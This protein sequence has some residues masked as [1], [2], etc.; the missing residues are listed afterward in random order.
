MKFGNY[1]QQLHCAP[2][3]TACNQSAKEPGQRPV[4]NFAKCNL[5]FNLLPIKGSAGDE[6][7]PMDVQGS[8]NNIHKP[9]EHILKSTDGDGDVDGQTR[10]YVVAAGSTQA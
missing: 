10:K 5:Q 7:Q 9:I 1:R 2:C 3:S 8:Y 4:W 6:R